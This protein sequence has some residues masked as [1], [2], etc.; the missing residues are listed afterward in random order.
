LT[1]P[2]LVIILFPMRGKRLQ[3]ASGGWRRF[4]RIRVRHHDTTLTFDVMITSAI[5]VIAVSESARAEDYYCLSLPQ[6]HRTKM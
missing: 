4:S 2:F 6:N 5:P 3:E 1:G